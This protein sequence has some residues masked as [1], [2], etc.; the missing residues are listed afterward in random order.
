MR[1]F[2]LAVTFAVVSLTVPRHSVAANLSADDLGTSVT[3]S[4]AIVPG[5]A[6]RLASHF[7]S[8]KPIQISTTSSYYPFPNTLYLNSPGGDVLE[9]V[10]LA[11]LVRALGLAVAV[12]PGAKGSCASSCFLIY[13]SAVARSAAGI[14][15]LRAQ[16]AR[17]NLGALGVH[18][19]YLREIA[20]GPAGAREQ[21]E[22]MVAMRA[23]LT[24]FG[25]GQALIDKMMSHA[26]NDIYWLDAEDIRALGA[27]SAGVE[28]Q[29]ISKCGYNSKRDAKQS[30]R[31]FLESMN[32][33]SGNCITAYMTATYDPVRLTT[34]DRMRQGWRPWK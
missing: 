7:M 22:V 12:A 13:V 5:D 25:V 20:S 11:E 30:A 28:E 16:G 34:V 14:D 23:H 10:R 27:Y 1:S 29:L 2:L 33:G 3:L 26:S 24:K 15:T 32:S 8:T 19:P 17:R 21:E 9:A 31:D 18:R 4:G 6:E